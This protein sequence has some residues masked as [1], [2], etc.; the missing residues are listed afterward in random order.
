MIFKP[1]CG[2]ADERRDLSSAGGGYGYGKVLP[3][4]RMLFEIRIV[5]GQWCLDSFD[6]GSQAAAGPGSFIRRAVV[7]GDG[8]LWQEA[9]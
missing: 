1:G 5:K 7:S 2:W 9:N 3:D 6:G 8:G 4:G